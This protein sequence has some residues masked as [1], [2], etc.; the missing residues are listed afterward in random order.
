MTTERDLYS[1]INIDHKGYY[2]KLFTRHFGTAQPSPWSI[3]FHAES[4]NN[5]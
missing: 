1:T 4:S 3:H 2:H 5:Q